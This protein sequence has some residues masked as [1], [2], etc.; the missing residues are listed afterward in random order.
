MTA[1]FK[2]TV[3]Y[4]L[5]AV[6]LTSVLHGDWSA[7]L[8]EVVAIASAYSRIIGGALV[9][10]LPFVLPFIL[11]IG[12]TKSLGRLRDAILVA[13]ASVL[14]QAGFLFFKSAIPQLVPF[15]ADPFWARLDQMLLFGRDS[16]EITHALTPS[17]LAD[18]FPQIYLTLWSAVAYAFPIVVVATDRD[19]ARAKRYVWLFFLSWVVAGNIV[20]LAGSS[21]GPIFYDQVMGVERFAD[22]HASLDAL[23]FSQGP[24]AALQGR[25]WENSTGML[26]LISAFP[27]VHVAVAAI[28]ALYIRERLRWAWPVGDAFYAMILLI[29]VYSG[30]HY[31]VDGLASLA[32]VLAL[33]AALLRRDVM[34]DV[35]DIATPQPIAGP[36]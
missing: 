5:G 22:L 30:Y 15:Y 1:I 25:L 11:L 9:D 36:R 21:V 35:G 13:V 26:S 27:S 7:V 14:L 28:V 10:A 19:E 32:I 18:W 16:W 4:V 6:A 31:L 23:G 12:L 2:T 8:Q 20:A 3:L 17:A 24:I 34:R 33:N 29:S